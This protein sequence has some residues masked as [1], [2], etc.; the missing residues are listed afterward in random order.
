[1]E[2]TSSP[3]DALAESA[4]MFMRGKALCAAVRLGIA[5]V[6]ADGAKDVNE[7]AAASKADPN[8]LR[9]LLRALAAI[10]V[11]E[12]VA[13]GRFALTPMG[14]PLAQSAPNSVRSSILFWADLIA[15]LWTYLPEC[16]RT[17][18]N[19][20]AAEAM[21]RTGAK[22]RWSIEPEAQAIFHDVFAEPGVEDM[23]PIVAAYDFGR[24]GVVADLGGAGGGLL[25]AILT[26]CPGA[27]GMLVD[28]QE[29]V[30]RAA[31]RL[32]SLGLRDRCQL[33][34][35]DLLEGV[36]AGANVYIMKSLLHGYDDQRAGRILENCRTAMTPSSRL[37]LIESVLPSTIR[38]G[39]ALVEKMLMSDLTMLAVTGGRER[40]EGDWTALLSSASLHLQRITPVAGSVAS[41][42]EARPA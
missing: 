7:L 25:A 30:D 20:G 32:A 37:L 2:S 21:E 38:A 15:D 4:R 5:D 13:S 10:G 39:D 26:A 12:E 28:R 8:S 1:M 34:A 35:G 14:E 31:A 22:S 17:G 29:A 42:I 3:R 36:P 18:G 6:L 41:I 33:I 23:A 11:V 16:V 40:S 19:S 27:S 9:R 24:Q